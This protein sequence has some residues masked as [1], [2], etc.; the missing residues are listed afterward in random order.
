MLLGLESVKQNEWRSYL[1]NQPKPIEAGLFN[2]IGEGIFKGLEHAKAVAEIATGADDF[3]RASKYVKETRADPVTVGAVGQ[4]LHGFSSIAAYGVMGAA[5]GAAVGGAVGSVIPGPG[6][7]VG[8]AFGAKAGAVGALSYLPGVDKYFEMREQGVDDETARE[9]AGITGAVMGL[10]AA[11]PAYVGKTL[12]AQVMSG[13]G[14][15]VPLGM[16]ERGATGA[17]LDNQYADVAKH[18]KALDSK[19]IALDMILGAAFPLGARAL[20]IGSRQADSALVAEG[21]VAAQ[22]RNPGLETSLDGTERFKADLVEADKLLVERGENPLEANLPRFG[23][24]FPNEEFN[25]MFA[26]TDDAI[27]RHIESEYG[28]S[29]ADIDADMKS[30]VDLNNRVSDSLFR[31]E[32]TVGDILEMTKEQFAKRDASIIA[33]KMP[34]I[35]VRD[36]NGVIR[37]ASEVI[38]HADELIKKGNED[39]FLHN[40]AIACS[41]THGD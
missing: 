7:I 36:A 4:V 25:K 28:V 38:E 21:D 22:T 35:Q 24:Q 15:N 17:L 32:Q 20:S 9:A 6:T 12:S 27:T 13:I 14:M 30:I 8:A 1:E 23:E 16:V 29:R 41:L 19:G 31:Q 2:G 26:R 11:L 37:S 5:G 10:S 34:D 33:E 3:D 18:Y 40:V 39:S